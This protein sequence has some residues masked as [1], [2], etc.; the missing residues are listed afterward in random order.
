MTTAT[1][2]NDES[3]V[4]IAFAVEPPPMTTFR[5]TRYEDDADESSPFERSSNDKNYNDPGTN[6]SS[7]KSTTS[8]CACVP[9]HADTAVGPVPE[10]HG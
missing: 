6:N 5:S 3:I 8:D 2:P 9:L 7:Q 4:S 1:V 10:S